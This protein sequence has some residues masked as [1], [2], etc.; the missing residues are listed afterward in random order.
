MPKTSEPE[1]VL[2]VDAGLFDDS[3]RAGGPGEE[4]GEGE[5][6]SEFAVRGDQVRNPSAP[7]S[8]PSSDDYDADT[9]DFQGRG[10]L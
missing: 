6:V 9:A 4:T 2:E 8:W 1:T 7:T 3:L 10:G 5:R